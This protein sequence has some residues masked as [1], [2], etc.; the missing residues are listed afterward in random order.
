MSDAPVTAPS[1][2]PSP[3]VS[4]IEHAVAVLRNLSA[5]RG[6]ALGDMQATLAALFDRAI[7]QHVALM[8]ALDAAWEAEK[9]SAGDKALSACFDIWGDYSADEVRALP[10]SVQNAWSIGLVHGAR[11]AVK[12]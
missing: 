6:L 1:P 11:A 9:D 10:P 3:L 7:A 8:R 4:A 2:S 12:R 5:A